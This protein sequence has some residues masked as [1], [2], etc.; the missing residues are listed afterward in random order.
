MKYEIKRVDIWSLA[1][2]FAVWG[3]IIGFI[4]GLIGAIF[5]SIIGDIALYSSDLSGTYGIPID[6]SGFET[7]AAVAMIFVYPIM[8]GICGLIG[9]VIG[10][11]FYNVVA[12]LVG[13]IEVDLNQKK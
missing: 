2:F 5:V 4:V 10:G 12:G 13:G 6:M 3:L 9:G 1:K 11:F 8:M 7:V